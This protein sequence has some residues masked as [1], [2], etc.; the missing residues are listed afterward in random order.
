MR[1]LSRKFWWLLLTLATLCVMSCGVTRNTTTEEDRQGRDVVLQIVNA[2]D[3]EL[4]RLEQAAA[5]DPQCFAKMKP[6]IAG[7]REK[8]EDARQ[9]LLQ[10]EAVH[11]K[12]ERPVIYSHAEV[13][14]LI[15]R[16]KKSHATTFWAS[17]GAAILAGGSIALGLARSPLAKLIPGFGNVF[18]AL[19]S[20]VEA[21]EAYMHKKKSGGE[22][23]DVK[24]LAGILSTAHEDAGVKGLM[25]K[26][27]VK[28]KDKLGLP[29]GPV[30]QPPLP[31]QPSPVEVVEEVKRET[32][33]RENPAA[34][35]GTST[36]MTSDEPK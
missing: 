20:T 11:G 36:T 24:E 13:P 17:V 3:E 26:V 35:E 10:L 32:E 4:N 1:L 18:G 28:A 15:E 5:E 29:P 12:P 31:V 19:S 2:D 16:I 9:V 14:G 23:D 33:R 7:M 25:D 6:F 22:V 27:L 8:H 30:V 34:A 21:V